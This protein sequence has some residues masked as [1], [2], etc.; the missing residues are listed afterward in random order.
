MLIR[1]AELFVYL[2]E[3]LLIRGICLF[4]KLPVLN[5]HAINSIHLACFTIGLISNSIPQCQPS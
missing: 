2:S 5:P 4:I 3:I 1:F